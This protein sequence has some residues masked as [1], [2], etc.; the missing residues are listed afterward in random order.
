MQI[1]Y[2]GLVD[3]NASYMPAILGLGDSYRLNSN[4]RKAMD[5]FQLIIEQQ[6]DNAAALFGHALTTALLHKQPPPSF[7]A[8][9]GIPPRTL[10]EEEISRICINLR[11]AINLEP[12]YLSQAEDEVAFVPF[13]DCLAAAQ[14]FELGKSLESQGDI[15]VAFFAYSEAVTLDPENAAYL[16]KL[17]NAYHHLKR[18]SEAEE[19]YEKA[20][21]YDSENDEYLNGFGA[22]YL[23]QRR[24]DKAIEK[25]DEAIKIDDSK[26]EYHGNLA[27]AYRL[28]NN[29]GDLEDAIDSYN[30]AV[31]LNE[32]YGDAYCGLGIS[33]E[34]SDKVPD[35]LE[36]LET[37]LNKS[38]NDD[39]EG[40]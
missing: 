11:K 20:L 1:T 5:S 2:Q 12:T 25:F 13:Q 15:A 26:A 21:F 39:F 19:T 23:D 8:S 9:L 32:E 7:Y 17:A 35:A 28:R 3:K 14:E 27:D 33:Y 38:L 31:S 36:P 30:R 22:F 6:P 29:E 4:Y 40:E 34:K 16:A 10:D 24:F 37:C 18:P